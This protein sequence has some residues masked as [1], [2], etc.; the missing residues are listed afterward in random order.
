MVKVRTATWEEDAVICEIARQSRFTRDFSTHRFFRTNIAASYSKG[1]VGVAVVRG[2]ILGFVYVKHLVRRSE[3]VIHYMGVSTAA[4]K[5][6]IGRQL[7]TWALRQSP[8]HY[9]VLSC[10]HVNTAGMEFYAR[11]GL[12]KLHEGV[13]GCERRYTRWSLS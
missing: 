8:H 9:V 3:S 1:E 11:V 12:C 4:Q 5:R 13:Y 2:E 10:E 7:L 6:G